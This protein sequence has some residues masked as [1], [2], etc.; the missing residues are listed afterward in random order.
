[1]KLIA[2]SREGAEFCYSRASAHLVS[3]RSAAKICDALNAC[4]YD[5][6]DGQIWHVHDCGPYELETTGAGFQ[7]FVIRN[8]YLCSRTY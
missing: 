7:K 6:N 3:D 1:M 2:K 5:L 8:G 4:R